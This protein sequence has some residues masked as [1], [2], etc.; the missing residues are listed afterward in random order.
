M[1]NKWP[2]WIWY[3]VLYVDMGILGGCSEPCPPGRTYFVP[4]ARGL[5]RDKGLSTGIDTSTGGLVVNG[6]T[7]LHTHPNSPTCSQGGR[8]AG[9]C[10]T[11]P[12]AHNQ[13]KPMSSRRGTQTEKICN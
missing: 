4:P 5:N 3:F 8:D 9:N 7:H 12:T 11:R 2:H 10:G 6:S 1:R 13:M